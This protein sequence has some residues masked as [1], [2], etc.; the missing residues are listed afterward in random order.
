MSV[1]T[2][3]CIVA[4]PATAIVYDVSA[5]YRECC[6]RSHDSR[7]EHLCELTLRARPMQE[8]EME[9]T[10]CDIAAVPTPVLVAIQT[11]LRTLLGQQAMVLPLTAS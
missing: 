9:P 10:V 8:P 7:G 3:H 5:D 4:D 6:S 1:A 11:K 2:I